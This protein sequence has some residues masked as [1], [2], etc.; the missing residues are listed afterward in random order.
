VNSNTHGELGEL[1]KQASEVQKNAYAPYSRFLVGAAVRGSSGRIYLGC[2][3][4]NASYG[5]TLCA[6]RSA[7][8]ALI[9]AGDQKFDAIAVYTES[10][11]PAMPCGLC[12]QVLSEFADNAVVVVANGATRR[13][14]PFSALL[15]EP[16]RLP[17]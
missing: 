12:R 1:V 11:E 7:I 6:E 8:A 13:E 2:N 14:L 3:V 17:R 16:F 15:P 9:A 10:D 5:A 4:E